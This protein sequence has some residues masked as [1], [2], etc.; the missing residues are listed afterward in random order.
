MNENLAARLARKGWGKEEIDKTLKIFDRAKHSISIET[1]KLQERVYW[2]FIIVICIINFGIAASLLPIMLALNLSFF[3]ILL[4][5]TGLV[6]GFSLEL[7]VRSMKH[8]E[9]KHHVSFGALMP[10]IAALSILIMGNV[11]NS[12][13]KEIGIGFSHNFYLAAIIYGVASVIPFF[14]H[15]FVIKR[16]Y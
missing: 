6:V 5:V 13:Q 7:V 8:L 2:I 12:I 14:M 16:Y 3:Y 11:S 15:R 9:D 1:K 10:F 4:A